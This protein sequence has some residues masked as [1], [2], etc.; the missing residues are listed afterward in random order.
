MPVHS[1]SVCLSVCLLT[2]Y[3]I[4]WYARAI[5]RTCK[6][7]FVSVA[8]AA[9]ISFVQ[10]NQSEL[11]NFR[12]SFE[13]HNRKINTISRARAPHDWSMSHAPIHDNKVPFILAP[14]WNMVFEIHV[15]YI[16]LC[17]FHRP[18][19]MVNTCLHHVHFQWHIHSILNGFVTIGIPYLYNN[20]S[21]C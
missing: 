12:R 9:R 20:A 15:C 2:E 3:I 10:L 17:T 16:I 4:I 13:E 18:K 19:S 6:T 8:A 11:I 21:N 1:L 7:Q 14:K 5:A